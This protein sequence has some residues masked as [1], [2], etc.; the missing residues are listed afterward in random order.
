MDLLERR[1]GEPQRHPWETARVQA[2]VEIL[3]RAGIGQP[4]VLDVGCGDAFVIAS[5]HSR[6]GFMTAAAQ[7]VHLTDQLI[8]ELS[9]PGVELVRRLDELG[10][11][12]FDLV[13]LLDVLEHIEKPQD[14]L[15]ELK[16]TRLAPGARVLVTVPAFQMLYTSHDTYLKHMRRYSRPAI[17]ELLNQ[18]DFEIQESGYLFSS[19]LVPRALSALRERVWAQQPK[20]ETGVGVWNAPRLLSLAVH[21]AL[22][23]DNRLCL[24]FQGKGLTLPGLSAWALCSLR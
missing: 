19:L 18:S 1:P 22:A 14:L 21:H 20:T 13:L 2:I 15:N 11:Q 8:A 16:R 5:L 6:L 3:E 10:G 12:R 24:W 9:R 7:D 4:R 17:C 23:I